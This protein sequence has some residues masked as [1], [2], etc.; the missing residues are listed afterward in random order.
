MTLRMNL[1]PSSIKHYFKTVQSASDLE[2]YD[3]KYE[4]TEAVADCIS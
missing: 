4:I 2:S 1:G 3:N